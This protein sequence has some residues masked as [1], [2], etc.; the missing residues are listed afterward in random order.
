MVPSAEATSRVAQDLGAVLELGGEGS[1]AGLDSRRQEL[2]R[3]RSMI[4][5]GDRHQAAQSGRVVDQVEPIAALDDDVVGELVLDDD[6]DH[7]DLRALAR[8]PGYELTQRPKARDE[9]LEERPALGRESCAVVGLHWPRACGAAP[10]L[11][12]RAVQA[13]PKPCTTEA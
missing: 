2:V 4:P 10:A 12:N 5:D 8:A 9:R 6:V 13:W 7:L 11:V 1:P 3:A